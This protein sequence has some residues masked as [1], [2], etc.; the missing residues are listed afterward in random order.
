[1]TVIIADR[2]VEFIVPPNCAVEFRAR[3]IDQIWR[4][5]N[6]EPDWGAHEW[7]VPGGGITTIIIR[8]VTTR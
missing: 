4:M 8:A 7:I 1:M 5:F 3:G 2:S 6:L